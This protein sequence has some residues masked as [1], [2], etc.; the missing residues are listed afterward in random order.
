M[1]SRPKLIEAKSQTQTDKGLVWTSSEQ[2]IIKTQ[3]Q[4]N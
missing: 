3:S 4:M 2:A 1:V